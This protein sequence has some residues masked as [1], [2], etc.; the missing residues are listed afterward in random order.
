MRFMML[1]PSSDILLQT[2]NVIVIVVLEEKPADTTKSV[3][4]THKY[5]YQIPLQSFL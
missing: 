2:T 1:H 5:L 3:E 4:F